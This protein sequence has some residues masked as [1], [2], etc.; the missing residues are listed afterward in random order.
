MLALIIQFFLV[1]PGLAV[2]DVSR[3]L[4]LHVEPVVP[5]H[6][7]LKGMVMQAKMSYSLW[8][9]LLVVPGGGKVPQMQI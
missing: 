6:N 9:R 1:M 7:Q 2:T 3:P 5:G 8:F 4:E